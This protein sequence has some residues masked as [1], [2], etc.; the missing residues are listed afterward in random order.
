VPFSAVR[1]L[2]LVI[3]ARDEGTRAMRGFARDIRMVGDTV[4]QANLRAARSAAMN[5]LAQQRLS[6]A[7]NDTMART[8]QHIG[9]IDKQIAASRTA[10]AALEQHRVSMQR[11]ASS[12]M[13][14][15]GALGAVGLGMTAIGVV[16]VLTMKGFVDAAV[17]YQKQTALTRTQVDGL[18]YSTKQL[19]DVGLRVARDIPVAFNQIQPALYDLFSSMELGI[20]DAE[21]LL[22]AFSKAAVA[23]STD[24]TSVSRATIGFLNAFKLPLSSVNHLLDVQFQLVQEGIGTYDEW[25]KRIG[26]AT[27]S[28]ARYGQSIEMLSAALAA[29][30]RMGITAARST[31][32]VSRAMDAMSNPKAVTALKKLGIQA[33]DSKGNFR[34]MIDVL[35][36]FRTALQ[37]IPKADR[38]AKILEVFKGAGGTIEA[39]RF[40]QNMLLLPGNIETFESIYKEMTTTSGS[41][42][43]AYSIMAD[44]VAGRSQMLANQWSILKVT[45]GDALIPMFLK[46]IGALQKAVEWFNNLSPSTKKLVTNI[47][48]LASILTGVGGLFVLVIAGIAAFAAVVG[49]AGIGIF[50]F[51]GGMAALAGAFGL[52]VAAVVMAWKKSENFRYLLK[53][54]WY[55]AKRMYEDAILPAA[56]GIWDAWKQ[57]MQPAFAALATIIEQKVM[58]IVRRLTDIFSKEFIDAAKEVANWIKDM[59][60]NAFKFVSGVITNTVIPAIEK[61]TAFYYA[62]EGTIK[63]LIGWIS[64][65]VK[66]FLKIAAVVGGILVVI[67]VGPVV[68]AFFAVIGA[69]IALIIAIVKIIEWIKMLI[70]WFSDFG[71][72]MAFIGAWFMS[73]WTSVKN[74]FINTWNTI[75]NS[76]F[77]IWNSIKNIFFTV[78]NAVSSFI[79]SKVSGIRSFLAGAWAGVLTTVRNVW[80]SLPTVIT[81]ALN[82][83]AGE[84]ARIV[85]SIRNFFAGALGWLYQA[86][87]NII[88]GLLNGIGSRVQ[89][90]KN[91]IGE[92]AQSILNRLPFSP[93]KAGPM[94]GRGNPFYRG[95]KIVELIAQGMASRMNALSVM[96]NALATQVGNL[97]IA[98]SGAGGGTS[99]TQNF[100]IYT[101]EINPRRHSEELGFLLAGR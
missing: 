75:K 16:G 77:S 65:A 55:W 71:K 6:G 101:N 18:R 89:A 42:E 87:A 94:A 47:A 92:I 58:P 86:G 24:V 96:S 56:K 52:F 74:F 1:D 48:I 83:A 12:M 33:V 41:F 8:I 9:A 25:V 51:L 95:Q 82:R 73:V 54:L 37:K 63:T 84:V 91:K 50:I 70:K 7:T 43:S 10:R 93:A 80:N 97:P 21:K 88:N 29:S 40:L 11:F 46:I 49:T 5:A 64:E 66:W 39:R 23:G 44:T 79:T 22:R 38:I 26:L 36:E 35:K 53:D 3:K 61:L 13:G 99:N 27:P 32:A 17:D 69:I 19:G 68:L 90:V 28:A 14:A 100:T 15:S 98:A 20:G 76:T 59:L 30:T 4:A 34:P 57:Y 60:V 62:H 81:S 85:G 67:F 78:L 45:A 72:H 31:T 2:W